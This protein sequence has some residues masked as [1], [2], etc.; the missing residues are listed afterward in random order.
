[1]LR[2]AVQTLWSH[3]VL[4]G[5]LTALSGM[6]VQAAWQLRVSSGGLT[7][8]LGLPEH[9][10]LDRAW[11]VPRQLGLVY[12]G[13]SLPGIGSALACCSPAS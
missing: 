10:G 7:A 5:G 6:A 4:L 1:M 3:Q 2:L 12:Q 13:A 9:P 11:P 8:L